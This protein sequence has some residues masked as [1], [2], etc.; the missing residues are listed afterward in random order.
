MGNCIDPQKKKIHDSKACPKNNK[1]KSPA[2]D[3]KVSYS[4][5]PA[6]PSIED[7]LREKKIRKYTNQPLVRS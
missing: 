3:S 6:Y 1:D 4:V 7:V 2:R 5:V